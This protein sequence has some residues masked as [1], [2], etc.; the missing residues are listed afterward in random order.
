[1]TRLPLKMFVSASQIN[2]I[3]NLLKRGHRDYRFEQLLFAYKQGVQ[4]TY[5]VE[6]PK[7]L[8]IRSHL[9]A[10]VVLSELPDEIITLILG[11]LPFGELRYMAELNKRFYD[12]TMQFV[13]HLYSRMRLTHN[14]IPAPLWEVTEKIYHLSGEKCYSCEGIIITISNQ[15]GSEGS[16]WWLKW[17]EPL[18][19][20]IDPKLGHNRQAARQY[21][22]S[23]R[24]EYAQY[25]LADVFTPPRK[26]GKVFRMI[27]W[28][29]P[30][31]E[32]LARKYVGRWRSYLA[33]V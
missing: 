29:N 2:G 19:T 11:Y 20:N 6:N 8:R 23:K 4:L 32:Q 5:E 17:Y 13:L 3:S 16:E 21:L 18:V 25:L 31:R 1:M 33:R 10:S 24:R 9:E 7:V 28:T 14:I 30:F 12:I 27:P 26:R 15:A 22:D